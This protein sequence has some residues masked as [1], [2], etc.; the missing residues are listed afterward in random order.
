[1]T[2]LGL[3]LAAALAAAPLVPDPALTPGV[4][5]PAVTQA[6]TATTICVA[7]YTAGGRHVS[8]ATKK[9][10]FAEYGVDRRSQHFEIDHL[11]S[12]ELGGANDIHNLWPQ[13]Y[14]TEPLNA[15]TKDALEDHLH[16]LV[17]SG[18]VPL[19]DAQ[20]AIVADWRTAYATYIGPLPA[21]AP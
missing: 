9:A 18:Q 14:D 5:D 16:A 4:V 6:T 11:I 13:S 2:T 12:L 20:A 21:A 10:V 17:C 7:G 19:A 8:G 1:M 3:A 15:H